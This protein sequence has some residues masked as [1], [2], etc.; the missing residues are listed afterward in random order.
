MTSCA[1]RK[2]A[3]ELATSRRQLRTPPGHRPPAIPRTFDLDDR[4]SKARAPE[5]IP[6]VK[7]I[8]DIASNRNLSPPDS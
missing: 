8:I 5:M 4:T 2:E 7:T 6:H 3:E 1:P